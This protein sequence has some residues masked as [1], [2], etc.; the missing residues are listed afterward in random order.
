MVSFNIHPSGLSRVPDGSIPAYMNPH[1]QVVA[2]V[3]QEYRDILARYIQSKVKDP[4]DSEELLSQVMMK[5]YDHCE[6]LEGVRN[7][8]A[9]LVT[10][11]RNAVTDYFRMQQ[12]RPEFSLPVSVALEEEANVMQDL[13]ACIPSLI[14]KLPEKY[15]KPLAD[16]ELRGIPQKSLAVQY[17]MSESGLKSR[18]QRGRKMLKELFTQYCGHLIEEQESCGDCNC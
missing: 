1:C 12:K 9:W 2:P 5:I 4:I 17:G 3:F 11:A 14:A 8:E 6:K 16:Y 15:A 18:V 13:E 10:I 7:T